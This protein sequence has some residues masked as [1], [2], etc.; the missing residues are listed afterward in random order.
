ML[1]FARVAKRAIDV[2]TSSCRIAKK[3]QVNRPV[4]QGHHPEVM[5]N[6][7]HQRAMFIRVV[8]RA[9]AIE[10][11]PSFGDVPTHKERTRDHPMPDRESKSLVSLIRERKELSCEVERDLAV[12]C[13]K[14][15]NPDAVE[16]RK[17]CQRVFGSLTKRLCPLDEN[18][19][20][21]KR[22][23]GLGRAIALCLHQSV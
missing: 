2:C 11:C 22:G 13:G 4:A 3:P 16:D 15:P 12:E 1:E 20:F 21:F 7:G 8:K 9:R 18:A 14:V 23:L 19:R 6:S 5:A 10:I 17:Q